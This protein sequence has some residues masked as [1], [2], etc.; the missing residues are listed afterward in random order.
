MLLLSCLW[1]LPALA[2]PN[3]RGN[4]RSDAIIFPPSSPP[5]TVRFVTPTLK[6][7][8]P[9]R[10]ITDIWDDDFGY[11][12]KDIN[13]ASY[14][15]NFPTTGANRLYFDL[16]IYGYGDVDGLTWMPVTHE[17]IT[18]TVK[19]ITRME[20][21]VHNRDWILNKNPFS[22]ARVT[23]TGPDANAQ[24]GNPH[25]SRIPVPRL[26]QTFELVGK[27][28][29]GEEVVKYGFVLQ[30]WF[31]HREWRGEA[32][33]IRDYS[34]AVA[35]CGGLGYRVPQVKELTNAVC[36]FHSCEGA[37]GATPPSTGNFSL[38][39]IG[40]GFFSE[41]GDMNAY[42]SANFGYTG[43]WTSDTT[44]WG[45]RLQYTVGP[46]GYIN[47]GRAD[48]SLELAICTTP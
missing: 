3:G 35:W 26:P 2:G 43:F 6:V 11:I 34:E 18:A 39:W 28:S 21:W 12:V 4:N 47:Y 41:W 44:T 32:S 22:Y 13:P 46:N 29:N 8:F 10:Y 9:N 37:I 31:V 14:A 19:P 20:S 42:R 48:Y 30:K 5:A 16:I 25:P 24:W 27:D 40:A 38:H 17:G 15:L 7:G 45:N 23:L 36:D 1:H 33:Y